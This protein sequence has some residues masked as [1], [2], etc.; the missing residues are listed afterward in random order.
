MVRESDWRTASIFALKYE[1]KGKKLRNKNQDL[2]DK[3]GK[4]LSTV[5]TKKRDCPHLDFDQV[6]SSQTSN[7]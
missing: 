7:Y 3:K 2:E 1:Q 4:R 6:R 5:S